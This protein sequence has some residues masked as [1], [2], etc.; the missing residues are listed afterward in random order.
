MASANRY[1]V[2]FGEAQNAAKELQNVLERMQQ[3]IQELEK[4]EE[5]LLNDR[6]WTGPNKN[7]FKMKFE[8]YRSG[9]VNLYNN[10]QEH[11]QALQQIISTY[12]KPE[13]G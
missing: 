12:Q 7:Q 13:M 6:L 11:L 10:G 9:M 2:H 8:E 4:V 1:E 5:E 3:Q